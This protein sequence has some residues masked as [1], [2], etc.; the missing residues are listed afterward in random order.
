MH[1]Y[2]RLIISLEILAWIYSRGAQILPWGAKESLL[3]EKMFPQRNDRAEIEVFFCL[4]GQKAQPAVTGFGQ[5][6]TRFK[7]AACVLL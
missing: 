1:R 4:V 3:C 2:S 7:D 6:I 5:R